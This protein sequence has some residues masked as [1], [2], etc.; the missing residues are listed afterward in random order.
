MELFSKLSIVLF[1]HTSFLYLLFVGS[2]SYSNFFKTFLKMDVVWN[3][4]KIVFQSG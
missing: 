1:M 4:Y 2:L 3:V